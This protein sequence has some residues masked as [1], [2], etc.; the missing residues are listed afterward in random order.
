MGLVCLQS[1]RGGSSDFS[2]SPCA[3]AVRPVRLLRPLCPGPLDLRSLV[4][5]GAGCGPIRLPWLG[6]ICD[7]PC[8]AVGGYVYC[9]AVVAPPPGCPQWTPTSDT[10][11]TGHSTLSRRVRRPRAPDTSAA[12]SMRPGGSN[13]P[14]G[15]CVFL[16][17]LQG[18]EPICQM[19]PPGRRYRGPSSVTGDGPFSCA[20]GGE[21]ARGQ[22][23]A[24]ADVPAAHCV[25][26]S[27]AHGMAPSAAHGVAP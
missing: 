12:P 24:R 18:G 6:L 20:G 27:A 10:A 2:S 14:P 21:W 11:M 17:L 8:S 13:R 9:L 15:P 23:W 4:G 25:A 1:S 19:H 22:A 16:R 3:P 26:Q 7:H 5:V